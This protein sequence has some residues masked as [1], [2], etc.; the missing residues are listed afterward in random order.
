LKVFKEER[1]KQKKLGNGPKQ[2]ALKILIDGGYGVF[3]AS[4]YSYYDPRVAEL[5]T[6]YGRQ[7]LSKMQ[8]IASTLNFE[9]VYGDTDIPLFSIH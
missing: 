8:D 6:A 7:T 5:I 1:L 4:D 3:G 2:L 9:I